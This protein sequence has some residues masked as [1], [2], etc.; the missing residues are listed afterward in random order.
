VLITAKC[1]AIM[2]R[3]FD[4]STNE[5]IPEPT[6]TYVDVHTVEVFVKVDFGDSQE[7]GA[8][9]LSIGKN[10][11]KD[12]V[13]RQCLGKYPKWYGDAGYIQEI[14]VIGQI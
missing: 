2:V 3:L 1:I 14:L 9:T 5:R 11:K 12:F 7:I 13:T 8:C 6:L 4:G 10:I